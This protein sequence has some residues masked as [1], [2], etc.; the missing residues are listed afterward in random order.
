[1]Y[2]S[3][4]VKERHTLDGPEK[5]SERRRMSDRRQFHYTAHSPERRSGTDRRNRDGNKLKA[6]VA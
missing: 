2:N 5:L 4:S 3:E 6:R 1:M